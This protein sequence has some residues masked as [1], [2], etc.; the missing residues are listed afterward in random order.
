VPTGNSI[1]F[2][3]SPS[4]VIEIGNLSGFSETG[5]YPETKTVYTYVFFTQSSENSAPISRR[6]IAKLLKMLFNPDC[7]NFMSNVYANA[8][9]AGS[10]DLSQ[11]LPG[12]GEV[13]GADLVMVLE[14]SYVDQRHVDPT[15]GLFHT[16]ATADYFAFPKAI[17]LYSGYFQ[18]GTTGQAQILAHEGLHLIFP[19]SDSQLAA[20]AGVPAGPNESNSANFQG[21][22]VRKC[23]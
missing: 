7:R 13:A 12:G 19:F 17:T 4:G 22:L 8:A 10:S 18:Q 1:P 16:A 21:A 15:N 3:V 11:V 20:A 6:T 14:A 23:K 9:S 5:E 2:G